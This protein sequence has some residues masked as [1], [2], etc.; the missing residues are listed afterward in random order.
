LRHFPSLAG[1][2]CLPATRAWAAALLLALAACGDGGGGGGGSGSGGGTGTVPSTPA[3]PP[4]VTKPNTPPPSPGTPVANAPNGLGAGTNLRMDGADYIATFKDPDGTSYDARQIAGTW[5][6][7]VESSAPVDGLLV[8]GQSNAGLV[9]ATDIDRRL[10]TP[11]F[12]HTVVGSSLAFWG[13]EATRWPSTPSAPV[14]DLYDWPELIGHFPAT[15]D[16]YAAEQVAR[17]AGRPPTGLY[18]YTQYEAGAAIGSFVKGS[19]NYQLLLDEVRRATASAKLYKRSF[20][21]RGVVWIQGET[22]SSDYGTT[23]ERL[24]D[25]LAAD[26]VA[27]TGQATRPEL[28]IQQINLPDAQPSITGVELDQLALAR[29]RQGSGITMIGPMYQGRYGAGDLMHVSDLGKM[30]LADVVGLAFDRV[31][32]GLP[33]T[34]LWPVAASRAGAVID[35]RFNV[36]G[37]GLAL[38]TDLLPNDIANYGFAYTDDAKSAFIQSVQIVGTDTVRLTLNRIP[39][40]TN[41]Q[42]QY[43]LGNEAASDGFSAGRGNLYSEDKAPSLY[44][45]LGYPVPAHVRH[46]AVRFALAV[47]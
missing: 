40:G 23:L 19:T 30:A 16:A 14:A 46:Y 1:M 45:R 5:G 9:V 36:P 39:F 18:A 6:W 10:R 37:N 31:R 43:A 24:A 41:A 27:I 4:I 29:R 25:D 8:Y 42:V 2:K 11:V 17:D 34:P 20:A 28:M 3:P 47:P 33:F 21:V 12:P 26:I 13:D 32:R 7:L 44:R 15:L 38:D 35:I 22:V